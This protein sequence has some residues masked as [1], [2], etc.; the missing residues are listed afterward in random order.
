MRSYQ[1]GL[2]FNNPLIPVSV[3]DEISPKTKVRGLS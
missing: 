3:V 2:G 1:V